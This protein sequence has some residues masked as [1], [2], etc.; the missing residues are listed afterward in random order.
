MDNLGFKSH[1][2]PIVECLNETNCTHFYSGVARG[3][4]PEKYA[5]WPEKYAKYVFGA[6]EADFWSKI[7]NSPLLGIWELKL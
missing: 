5:N 6:F 2:D 4:G 3:R 1:S 7:E